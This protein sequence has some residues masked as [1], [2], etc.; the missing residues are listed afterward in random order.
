HVSFHAGD[1]IVV[2]GVGFHSFVMDKTFEREFDGW[3]KK[4]LV[5]RGIAFD[6]M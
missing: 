1:P 5:G 3:V 2:P 4:F 6:E